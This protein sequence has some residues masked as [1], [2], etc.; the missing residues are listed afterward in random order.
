MP[1]GGAAAADFAGMEAACRDGDRGGTAAAGKIHD[2]TEAWGC[3]QTAT[4]GR[5]NVRQPHMSA[6]TFPNMHTEVSARALLRCWSSGAG[7]NMKFY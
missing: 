5:V 2:A 3:V 4:R 7:I 1:F 6:K